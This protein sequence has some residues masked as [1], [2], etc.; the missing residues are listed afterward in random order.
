MK[1]YLY[2]VYD[3]N[4]YVGTLQ[5]VISEFNVHQDINSAGAE[6]EIELGSTF[7]EAGPIA[8]LDALV[9]EDGDNIITENGDRILVG[10]DYSFNDI[11]INLGNRVEVYMFYD[12][13]PNGTK[14]FDG[15]ISQWTNLENRI[16]LKVLSYGYE[17]VN[18]IIET[19]ASIGISQEVSDKEYALTFQ[20][21]T[22]GGKGQSFN[23]AGQS[24][25]S[26][27][28]VLMRSGGAGV[29]YV[30]LRLYKN[31]PTGGLGEF[32]GEVSQDIGND[33]EHFV[34]FVFDTPLDLAAGD[35]TFLMFNGGAFTSSYST[36]YVKA[37]NTNPYAGGQLYTNSTGTGTSGW[38]AVAGEDMAFTIGIST[39]SIDPVFENEEVSNI[40]RQVLDINNEKG[41]VITYD[42][43]S[44]DD[45]GAFATYDFKLATIL[46]GIEK[47]KELAPA[48]WFWYVDLS[49]NL[50]HFHSKGH[51]AD[52]IMIRGKHLNSLE[53]TRS[54]EKVK[55][56]VYFSG[57]DTGS[58][59]NL[60]RVNSNSAS[61]GQYGAWLERM[62]DNR[63][64]DAATADIISTGFLDEHSQ[65]SFNT[66]IKVPSAVYDIE[67]FQLGEMVG[68]AN[69]DD[70]TNDLLLQI[71]GI[72]R[73]PDLVTLYL[74]TVPPGVSELISSIQRR[75]E[76]QETENNPS[77]P[78]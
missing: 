51:S 46:E 18:N 33:P 41:G 21:D 47:A 55:N 16:K 35:Y 13:A 72:D 61:I 8:L 24:L 44:I 10:R 31:T 1:T 4:Q 56:I 39:G 25:V 60:F 3:A 22:P 43:N 50:L 5:N 57:G 7:D 75:L 28:S 30:Y 73:T 37:T 23:L 40:I 15:V 54:I 36:P 62:S 77:S 45:T 78:N 59:E 19:P 76:Y 11:P 70:L 67:T 68:F 38:S 27:I 20:S 29:T 48:N 12:Q 9:K 2:K 26:S 66:V 71:V 58:G 63:V 34:N 49:T 53:V 42:E 64:I 52:H 14:V 74:D 17:L 6:L 65:P 69:F 32:L